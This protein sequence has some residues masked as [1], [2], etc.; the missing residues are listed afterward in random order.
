MLSLLSLEFPNDECEAASSGVALG[1]ATN[2]RTPLRVGCAGEDTKDPRSIPGPGQ[3]FVCPTLIS[4]VLCLAALVAA[5]AAYPHGHAY[6]SQHINRHDGPSHVIHGHDGH[7]H[8]YYAYPKYDFAYEVHDPHTHDIKSQAEHRDGDHVKGYY[9]LHQP[10]GSVRHVDYYGDKHSGFHANVKHGTHHIVPVDWYSG[11]RYPLDLCDL[12][13]DISN[14]TFNYYVIFINPFQ[15]LCLAALVATAVAQ[16]GHG[17]GYSSQH[18]HRHDGPAHLV[19]VHGH[20]G[21]HDHDYYAY[22][23]YDFAYEVKDPHT[24]D[25]KSQAEHRDGDHVKGYYALHQPDGS[26]RHVDYHGDKHSG[27]H[28]DVKHSVHHIVPHHHHHY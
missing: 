21:H 12:K 2:Q 16:Y 11:N 18:I 8:D 10:D 9:A 27:F 23:K 6:S 25:I 13:I 5:V 28:A 19:P 17:H 24:H 3:I 26:I 15:V 20:H 1:S 14:L 4:L 22:P 7:G